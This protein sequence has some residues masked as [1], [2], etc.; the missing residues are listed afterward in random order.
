ME[1]GKNSIF[2]QVFVQIIRIGN[3]GEEGNE[4]YILT[5]MA[6]SL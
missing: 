3:E 5:D 2:W 1:P 6:A 4:Q